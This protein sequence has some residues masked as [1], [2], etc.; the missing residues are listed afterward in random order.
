[1]VFRLLDQNGLCEYYD[2]NHQPGSN[3]RIERRKDTFAFLEDD[4]IRQQLISYE[5]EKQTHVTFYLPQIRR[6]SCLYLL[7]NLLISSTMASPLPASN[8]TRAK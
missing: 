8:F 1:M 5:D 2:L 3:Q 6:S 7:E 4:K